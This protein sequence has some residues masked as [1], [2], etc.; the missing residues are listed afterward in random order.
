MTKRAKFEFWAAGA[1]LTFILIFV[2]YGLAQARTRVR[3][4]LRQDDIT[5]LKR[6]IEQYNNAFF[7]YPTPP[8]TEAACTET[9]PDSWLL[10]NDSPLVNGHFIDAIPHDVREKSGHLYRYCATVVENGKTT[11]Y[12]LEAELEVDQSDIIA[13]DEDEER[14]FAYRI[15]HDG[16]RILYRVCGGDENQCN[17]EE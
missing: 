5:N 4:T 12:Y 10:G 9:A 17:L 3:D 2:V 11:G 6:A 13:F 8:N 16:A 1:L 15:L 7:A 14:K